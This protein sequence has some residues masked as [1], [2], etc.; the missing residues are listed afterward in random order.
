LVALLAAGAAAWI[1]FG[2]AGAIATL[3]GFCCVECPVFLFY[4][5]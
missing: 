3:Y 4:G 5:G 2:L 1:A